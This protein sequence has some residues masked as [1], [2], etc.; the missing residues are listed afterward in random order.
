ME[1]KLSKLKKLMAKD[2]WKRALSIASKFP[3]LG[4]HKS[5]IQRGHQAYVNPR[6]YEQ[7]GFDITELQDKGRKALI[8]RYVKTG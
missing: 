3:R 4:E 6:S 8:A 7:L 5:D 2:D 1:T